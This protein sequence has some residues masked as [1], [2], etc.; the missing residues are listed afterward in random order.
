MNNAS[1][2]T[3]IKI[4]AAELRHLTKQWTE[5][6]PNPWDSMHD[7]DNIFSWRLAFFTYMQQR[8]DQLNNLNNVALRGLLEQLSST[9]DSAWTLIEFAKSARKHSFLEVSM[10][11]LSRIPNENVINDRE[12]YHNQYN[13][14]RERIVICSK[15]PAHLEPGLSIINNTNLD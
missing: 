7:W 3:R 15:S 13:Q 11:I 6:M 9:Q 1:L 5:R 4:T 10:N 14:L 8:M 12:K 2:D